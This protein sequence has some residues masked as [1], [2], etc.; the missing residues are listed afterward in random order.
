[1]QDLADCGKHILF[2]SARMQLFTLAFY[3]KS[4]SEHLS[5]RLVSVPGHSSHTLLMTMNPGLI[6]HP[7]SH[8]NTPATIVILTSLS[9]HSVFV[10]TPWIP[11]TYG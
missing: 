10:Q 4:F 7:D 1:M 11:V 9:V 2:V 3:V 6:A 5:Q 8:L